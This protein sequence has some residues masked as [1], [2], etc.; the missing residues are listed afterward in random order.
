MVRRGQVGQ[1][2]LPSLPPL[3]SRRPPS[4]IYRICI[5]AGGRSGDARRI[6]VRVGRVKTRVGIIGSVEVSEVAVWF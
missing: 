3:L 6:R 4:R 5:W 1:T 2:V